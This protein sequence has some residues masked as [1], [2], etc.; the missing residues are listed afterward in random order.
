MSAQRKKGTA[1]ETD[2][3]RYLRENKIGADRIPRT[4]SK[5]QGDVVVDGNPHDWILEAKNT[6]TMN[7]ASAVDEAQREADNYNEAHFS[8]VFGA[9][10]IK[11]RMKGV[12]EAY[13]VMPLHVFSDAVLA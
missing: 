12:E 5:D 11:R 2:V 6:R 4:G 13:V 3:V 1:F 10:V 8:H 7:V 9:A